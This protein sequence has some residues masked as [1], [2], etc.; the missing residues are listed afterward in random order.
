VDE[1]SATGAGGRDTASLGDAAARGTG[2]TL[3]T[4]AVRAVLQFASVVVIARLLAPEDFGLIAMVAAV[5]GVADLVRDF[6][7]STAAIQASTLSQDE[8][9]NLFWANLG[10]GLLCSLLSV[11]AAPLIVAV[12]D[13]PRLGPIVLALSCVFVL[14]GA[15]TQYQADLTRSL[16]LGTLGISDIAAQ[17]AGIVVAVTSALLGAEYWALVAQQL[18]VAVVSLGLNAYRAGWLPGRPRR[19]VSLRHFF[20]F[21]GGLLGTQAVGYLVKNV[22]NIALGAFAGAAPLGIYSRAYQ[23]LMT[24]LNTI[25]APMTRVAVPVLSKVQHDDVVFARYVSRVQVVGCLVTATVFSVAAGLAEPLVAVLFGPRWSDV[26]PVFAVLA[27]GGVF[28]SVS[29]I[30]YWVYLARGVPGAQFRMSLVMAPVM[31]GLILAGLP[32][33]AVGVATGHSVAYFV[34]WLVTLAH[35][36]RAARVASWPLFTQALRTLCLVSVPAGVAASL[37]SALAGPA[38]LQLASGVAA[39]AV[40]VGLM[41]LAVPSLRRDTAV[42]LRFARRA[43][44]R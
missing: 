34:M 17:S 25:N 14:S 30:A 7:L 22:D 29:Q 41:H 13:E 6:G 12:F 28:R 44:G 4:Q 39:A 23:L 9:T 16:R 40:A 37:G 26:A 32:W 15:N 43:V 33:G 21:G 2:S 35:V 11:A 1:A 42:L 31:V 10:L 5:I 38:V 20:R 18:T 8:R 3:L 24:P 19:S 36:G 27:I